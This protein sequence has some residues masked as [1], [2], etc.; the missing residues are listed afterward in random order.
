MIKHKA[1]PGNQS[2]TQENKSLRKQAKI[3][4]QKQEKDPHKVT[5]G[6]R[7]ERETHKVLRELAENG[8]N[9]HTSIQEGARANEDQVKIIRVIKKAGKEQ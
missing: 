4:V 5:Q 8:G 6:K 7:L 9:T 2:V 1:K 3:K